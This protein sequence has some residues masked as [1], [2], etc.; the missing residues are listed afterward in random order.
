MFAFFS[1]RVIASQHSLLMSG[2]AGHIYVWLAIARQ[3]KIATLLDMN[4]Y[5]PCWYEIKWSFF[6]TLGRAVE[7]KGSVPKF[8]TLLFS[9]I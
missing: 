5:N 4:G 1:W 2:F 3:E 7:P 6:G 9:A 8:T